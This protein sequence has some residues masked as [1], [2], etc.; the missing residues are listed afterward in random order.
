MHSRSNNSLATWPV[1]LMAIVCGVAYT[2]AAEDPA[3]V[4]TPASD[5]IVR[6]QPLH[7]APSELFLVTRVVDGDTI[8]VE[9]E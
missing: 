9:R 6:E 5:R 7:P 4:E 1:L 2:P 8:D 3:P